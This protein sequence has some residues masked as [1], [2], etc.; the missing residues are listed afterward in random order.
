MSVAIYDILGK[1]VINTNVI[2]NRVNVASLNPGIYMLQISQNGS[3]IT[4]KLVVK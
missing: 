3:S 4:K 2:N 1:R